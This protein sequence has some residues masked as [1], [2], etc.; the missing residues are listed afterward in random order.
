MRAGMNPRASSPAS[1]P[2][3]PHRFRFE[4]LLLSVRPVPVLRCVLVQ[5]QGGADLGT[6]DSVEFLVTPRCWSLLGAPTVQEAPDCGGAVGG[7]SPKI[8]GCP[9]GPET[10][11][12]C[13]HATSVRLEASTWRRD[14]PRWP[15]GGGAAVVAAERLRLVRSDPNGRR[16]TA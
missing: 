5:Q 9:L 12:N 14:L 7:S 6:F 4:G 15:T 1:Q 3:A 13:G 8:L 11:N 16:L 10:V 2:E